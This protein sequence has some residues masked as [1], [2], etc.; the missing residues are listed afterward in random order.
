M[1]TI[2]NRLVTGCRDGK[3]LFLF[4]TQSDG[5]AREGMETLSGLPCQ[6]RLVLVLLGLA[7]GQA[8]FPACATLFHQTM[9]FVRHGDV[10]CDRLLRWNDEIGSEDGRGIDG[11]AV[12][13]DFEEQV[14]LTHHA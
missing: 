13:M 12:E 7:L 14:S 8:G 5:R 2:I 11:I 9:L 4:A 3:W 1:S 10:V 6:R